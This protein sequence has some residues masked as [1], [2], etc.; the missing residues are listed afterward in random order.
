MIT[1]YSLSTFT[2]NL[3]L[4]EIPFVLFARHV[5]WIATVLYRPNTHP[6]QT[7]SIVKMLL[8]FVAVWFIDSIFTSGFSKIENVDVCFLVY[9]HVST[10]QTLV[11]KYLMLM[12]R[13]Y[14]FGF[15]R[16][17]WKTKLP[18]SFSCRIASSMHS[19]CCSIFKNPT[20]TTYQ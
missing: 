4:S 18:N 2:L 16:M 1:I 10:V 7:L 9:S 5:T 14:T 15:G 6:S 17:T 3:I 8:I 13:I 20:G 11:I 19:R 12:P